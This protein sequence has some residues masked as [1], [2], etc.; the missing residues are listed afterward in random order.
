Q[1]KGIIPNECQLDI[2][3]D[4]SMIENFAYLNALAGNAWR[5]APLSPAEHGFV[6]F[7]EN[8]L[9]GIFWQNSTLKALIQSLFPI[10]NGSPSLEI[11]QKHLEP[12]CMINAL[13]CKVGTNGLSWS[14]RKKAGIRAAI[15][16]PSPR[17]IEAHVNT[18]RHP[19]F[20]PSEYKA[21]GYILRPSTRTD[22]F[23]LQVMAFK[24]KE[25]QSVR[26]KRYPEE[27]LPSGLLS[28]VGGTDDFLTKIRN[29][30][31]LPEAQEYIGNEA[32]RVKILGLDLGQSCT[33]AAF[34]LLPQD[35]SPPL[36]RNLAVK[37]KAIYQP[38]LKHRHWMEQR[39][40]RPIP[41][42]SVSITDI[43]SS[44]PPL[45]GKGS[46]YFEYC[47]Q[48]EQAQQKLDQFYNDKK[49]VFKRRSWGAQRAKQEE[50]RTIAER[51]LQSVG[52]SLHHR[53][54]EDNKVIISIGLGKFQSKSG[55][56]SLHESFATYFVK[57]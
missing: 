50:Y 48:L 45:R 49:Q 27:K 17:E 44:L 43:E 16:C 3:A 6:S 31:H 36:F 57:T 32:E 8:E 10:T 22:G 55:M 21:R 51:L 35:A 1:Q 41:G 38:S 47:Q 39:K 40:S 33:V 25:L 4:I 24:K 5:L 2:R 29:V 53:R 18:L 12:G 37:S 7:S 19:E 54:D 26:F 20:I 23:R 28:T 46:S 56:T 52:G 13:L 42:T 14:Q 9:I 11:I 34:A 15:E 30:I